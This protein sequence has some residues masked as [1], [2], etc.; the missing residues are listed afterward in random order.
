V[1]QLFVNREEELRFLED[2]LN[3]G[4]P[5]LV[6]IYGRR[7]IGKTELVARFMKGKPAIYFLADRRPERDLLLELRA[8]MAQALQDESFAKLE[9]KDWLELFEE[10]L[11]WWKR[12]RVIIALDEFPALIEGN[13]A[14]PS[15]FQKV[16]DLKL[17]DSQ[18]MLILLGSSVG[19]M[20]TE[21]LGYRSPLYGP[22]LSPQVRPEP[23]LLG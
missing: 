17:K 14:I 1:I 3:S 16:W 8:K 20:E 10:F 2:K 6:V 9:V 23:I 12:G 18:V 7:R 5:E 21:V 22:S 15:I 19:M 13:R 4:S 11:K